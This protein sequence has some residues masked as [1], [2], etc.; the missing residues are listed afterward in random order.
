[1]L[2]FDQPGYL[3]LLLL[4]PLGVYFRHFW[5]K[6]GGKIAFPFHVWKGNGFSSSQVGL[7]IL[8]YISGILFWIGFCFLIIGLAGPA[9]SKRERVFLNRGIDIMIVID[10][11]P[12]MSARDFPPINRFEAARAVIKKFVTSREND[13]IG[14]VSFSKEA[15]LRVPPTL[16]YK[17]LLNR[18]DE[19]SIMSLGDGT[20]IGMGIA[21]AGL[22]LKDSS[23][24]N[25]IIILLTDG[26]HNSGEIPPI[27]AA[28]IASRMGIK[29]YTIGVGSKGEVPLE[30]TD[31]STGKMYRGI[32]QSE[33]DEQLLKNIAAE[34]GGTYYHAASIGSLETV[35][36]K[37]DSI[38]TM[39]KRTRIEVTKSPKHRLVIFLGCICILLDFFIRKWALWEA[40]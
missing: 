22:H 21:V 39:G 32:F 35:F 33:F 11:S 37:I 40:L 6:R 24:E 19:L 31:P 14:L 34:T 10:E 9:M 4:I 23:A 36:K 38:E 30:Y 26:E 3:L 28:E 29:I 8:L 25:K 13:P 7:T 2:T 1:M 18:L 12:S 20:A 16:D 27:T 15:A 5:K 17:Y